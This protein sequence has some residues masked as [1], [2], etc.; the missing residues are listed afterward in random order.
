MRQSNRLLR[1]GLFVVALSVALTACSGPD[2]LTFSNESPADVTISTGNEEVTVSAWGGASILGSGC[3]KGDV[4]VTF[5]SGQK[6]VVAGPICPG[7]QI[8]VHDGKVDLQHS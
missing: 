8:V 7:E 5:N 1:S 3:S 2:D 6:V 4:I